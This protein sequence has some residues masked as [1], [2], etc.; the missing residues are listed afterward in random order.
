MSDYNKSGNTNVTIG[1][2]AVNSGLPDYPKAIEINHPTHYGG[3][4]TYEAIKVIEAWE[5]NFNIGNA[6][7]YLARYKKKGTPAADLE[8]AIW[9]IQRELNLVK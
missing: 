8:K 1:N 2:Y 6:L 7:K 3:D 5:A 9:Y 4:S